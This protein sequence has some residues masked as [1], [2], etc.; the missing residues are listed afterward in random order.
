MKNKNS[1]IKPFRGFI[2]LI[3]IDDNINKC[4]IKED[5]NSTE[6]REWYTKATYHLMER[7]IRRQKI[8]EDTSDYQ[9]F[10]EI[11]KTALK[12]NRCTFKRIL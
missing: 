11:M 2:I 1:I 12:K 5:F 6:K 3:I 9:V 10:L 4:N 7:G 8:F